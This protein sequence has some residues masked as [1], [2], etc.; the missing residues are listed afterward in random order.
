M[1]GQDGESLWDKGSKQ[2]FFYCMFQIVINEL[3]GY[4]TDKALQLDSHNSSS[5][6]TKAALLHICEFSAGEEQMIPHPPKKKR[7]ELNESLDVPL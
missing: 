2:S 7:K 6:K 4:A 1:R 3:W 5:H